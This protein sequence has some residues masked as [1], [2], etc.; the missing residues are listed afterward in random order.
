MLSPVWH[1]AG[2]GRKGATEVA[3]LAAD[4][5]TAI[6]TCSRYVQVH[7]VG[8][9]RPRLAHDTVPVQ[10]E[11]LRCTYIHAGRLKLGLPGGGGGVFLLRESYP[12]LERRRRRSV[13]LRPASN[14]SGLGRCLHPP[15]WMPPVRRL[16][17][18]AV[19]AKVNVRAYI[20]TASSGGRGKGGRPRW[21]VGRARSVLVMTMVWITGPGPVSLSA[22]LARY[23][24]AYLRCLLCLSFSTLWCYQWN[25]RRR[26]AGPATAAQMNG[27]TA[28]VTTLLFY[29]CYL[30]RVGDS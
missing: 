20:V 8:G 11:A 10:D 17:V 2:L 21:I 3:V 14:A 24:A 4:V 19:A 23:T 1:N 28:V 30:G 9:A 7:R 22:G 16:F 29:T 13:S 27:L 18:D 25:R 26:H 6:G 12:D 15:R 5:H